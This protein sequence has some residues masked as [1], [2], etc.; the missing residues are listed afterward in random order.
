MHFRM[1]VVAL[2]AFLVAGSAGDVSACGDKFLRIGRSVRFGRYGAFYPGSILIY[3]PATSAPARIKDLAKVI[4]RAGHREVVVVTG[5]ADLAAAMASRK[6]DLVLTG[7]AESAAVSRQVL[8]APSRP[9]ILPVVVRPTKADLAMALA[10]S[11]CVIDASSGHRNDALA[12][13]DCRME[14]RE[15]GVRAHGAGAQ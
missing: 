4:K 14:F 7:L 8:A 1:M 11:A 15:R 9:D 13:I 10:L 2:A 12:Q 5:L 3:A 6:Y